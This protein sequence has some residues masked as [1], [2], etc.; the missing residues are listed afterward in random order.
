M[1]PTL[2][3]ATMP[4]LGSVGTVVFDA[5]VRSFGCLR[6][7]AAGLT[8]RAVGARACRPRSDPRADPDRRGL[9]EQSDRPVPGLRLAVL[10]FLAAR[11]GEQAFADPA[12]ARQTLRRAAE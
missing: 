9:H 7:A 6:M 2:A 10:L 12:P 11:G 3:T 1:S 4:L 5:I 8:A